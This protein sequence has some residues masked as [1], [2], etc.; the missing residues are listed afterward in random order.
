[1]GLKVV[2]TMLLK[3][4]KKME[5][6]HKMEIKAKNR[7]IRNF[8]QNNTIT[9]VKGCQTDLGYVTPNVT[10]IN[11]PTEDALLDQLNSIYEQR[12]FKKA[13]LP[14]T[15]TEDELIIASRKLMKRF[16]AKNT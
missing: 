1:M 15:H 8:V 6:A 7:Y 4:I 12:G 10:S 14:L 13:K 2:N 9:A 16:T 5:E 11:L 3:Q